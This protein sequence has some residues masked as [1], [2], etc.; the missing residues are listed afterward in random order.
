MYLL[1]GGDR[2][3]V[4]TALNPTWI[5]LPILHHRFEELMSANEKHQ[6][7][8]AYEAPGGFETILIVEDEELLRD[9]V[10][11]LLEMKGYAILT[12]RDGQEAIEVYTQHAHSIQL[13]LTDLGLPRL[14]GWEACKRMQ[15][16]NPK[17]KIVVAS[18]YLDPSAKQEMAKGGVRR[19]VNKPYLATELSATIR[20]LLDEN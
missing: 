12:A 15:L 17:L 16:L 20:E 11:S 1:G 4:G 6:D 2:N 5:S 13:V 14:G 19:F 9:L 8:R 7:E 18:G 3:V 10:H